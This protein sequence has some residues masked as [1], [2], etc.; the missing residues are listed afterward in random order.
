MKYI[1]IHYDTLHY[2]TLHYTEVT[3]LYCSNTLHFTTVKRHNHLRVAAG[4][5]NFLL[6]FTAIVELMDFFC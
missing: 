6:S 3:T 1:G 5:K 4:Q 2:T